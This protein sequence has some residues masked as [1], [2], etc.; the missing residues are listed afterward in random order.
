VHLPRSRPGS[1]LLCMLVGLI[2]A[3]ICYLVGGSVSERSLRSWLRLLVFLWGQPPSQ[4]RP[5][6]HRG[7]DFCLLVGCKY[8]H[9]ILPFLFI[10]YFL[11]LQFLIP[12]APHHLISLPPASMRVFPYPSTYSTLAFAYTR[13]HSRGSTEPS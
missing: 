1:P 3:G 2:L 4:L 12:E 6:F 13:M 11:Y 5:A 10:G 7:P 9:L 8:L